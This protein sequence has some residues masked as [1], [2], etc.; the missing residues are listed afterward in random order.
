MALYVSTPDGARHTIDSNRPGPDNWTIHEIRAWSG[1]RE[2]PRSSWRATAQPFPW[3]IEAALDGRLTSFWMCGNSLTPGQFAQ[4][5]FPALERVDHV[6]IETALDQPNA[7]IALEA[8]NQNGDWERLPAPE[9]RR[10]R[11]RAICVVWRPWS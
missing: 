6:V 5:D 11:F 7:R 8:R 9:R 1:D 10:P 3:G 4:F 2:L